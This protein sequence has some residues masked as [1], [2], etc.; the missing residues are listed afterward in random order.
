VKPLVSPD[1]AQNGPVRVEYRVA[2][3][4]EVRGRRR[5][6][7]PPATPPEA[8]TEPPKQAAPAPALVKP[9][10]AT[11]IPK[12]TRLLVLAHHFDRLVRDGDVQGYAEIAMLTGLTR[13]RVTQIVN[14]RLLAP[15]IQDTILSLPRDTGISERHLRP[16][17]ACADWP[18]QHEMWE[19]LVARLSPAASG[20]S[21][22]NRLR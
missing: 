13:A 10:T 7:V 2:F 3:T 21:R 20:W 16:I 6:R 14:L 22:S 4:S 9:S 11:E 19:A 15:E 12:V 1:P 18:S 8:V 5:D 17:V